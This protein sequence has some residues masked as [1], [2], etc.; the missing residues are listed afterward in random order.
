MSDR[1]NSCSA[2][3][4]DSEGAGRR[5][6]QY[7]VQLDMDQELSQE[8][9]NTHLQISRFDIIYSIVEDYNQ[10]SPDCVEKVYDI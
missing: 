1:N 5:I 4:S 7:E 2:M 8:C 9:N 6:I 10:R 3:A